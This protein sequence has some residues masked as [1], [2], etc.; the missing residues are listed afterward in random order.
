MLN[1]LRGFIASLFQGK[2]MSNDV[3]YGYIRDD[4]NNSIEA[5]ITMYIEKF[6]LVKTY[7]SQNAKY[8]ID[9]G[10]ITV[11]AENRFKLDKGDVIYLTFEGSNKKYECYITYVND[12]N[13]RQDAVL[14]D[15]DLVMDPSYALRT[16]G[17]HI[18]KP[19][20]NA[21]AFK[22]RIFVCNK[23]FTNKYQICNTDDEWSLVDEIDSGTNLEIFLT[24]N[25]YY[26]IEIIGFRSDSSIKDR[27]FIDN[28]KLKLAYFDKE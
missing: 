11:D 10:N 22:Y 18:I 13:I 6:K 28:R 26:K 27:L 9:L 25:S 14:V 20:S 1:K 21:D 3:I 15:Y 4:L 8:T 19:N 2:T 17:M 24:K 12:S 5:T 7:T 16:D 23:V